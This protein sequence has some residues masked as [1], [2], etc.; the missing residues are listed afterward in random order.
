MSFHNDSILRYRRNRVAFNSAKETGR[1]FVVGADQFLA[2]PEY[3]Y[4]GPL[5]IGPRERRGWKPLSDPRPPGSPF[6]INIIVT[7]KVSMTEA[8]IEAEDP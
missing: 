3:L 2:P 8:E 5:W 6:R 4:T 1:S 7:P